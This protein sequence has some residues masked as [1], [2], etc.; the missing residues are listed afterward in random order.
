M[1]TERQSEQHTLNSLLPAEAN[2]YKKTL[3][4]SNGALYVEFF[5]ADVLNEIVTESVIDRS[6]RK[7]KISSTIY[8]ILQIVIKLIQG[9]SIH[10]DSTIKPVTTH[11]RFCTK[12]LQVTADL[13]AL[14]K[15]ISI[16][17]L[18]KHPELFR[19]S[20]SV[21]E[22]KQLWQNLNNITFTALS[23]NSEKCPEEKEKKNQEIIKIISYNLKEFDVETIAS[24]YKMI[25]KTKNPF[26]S[27]KYINE[28]IKIGNISCKKTKIQLC[29]F[30]LAFAVPTQKQELLEVTCNFLYSL[31]TKEDSKLKF[32][33]ISVVFAPIF[34]I[35]EE[36]NIIDANFKE[37]MEKLKDLLEFFLENSP[38][39]FLLSL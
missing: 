26:F 38:Q 37:I 8:K 10:S 18:K 12:T 28:Y 25:L 17:D 22:V 4:E 1:D 2:E 32:R 6:I 14:M 19:Q 39:I 33:N 11:Y 27:T 24:V 16:V 29:K 34:F 35:D 30:I 31:I 3:I 5:H 21:K 23:P 13:E 20:A 7:R 9:N 15:V 36:C